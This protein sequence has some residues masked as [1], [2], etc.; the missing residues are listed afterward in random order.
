[1]IDAKTAR[2]LVVESDALMEKY[3]EDLGKVIEREARLGRSYL[4]PAKT[5]GLQF[6]SLYDVEHRAYR[7]SELNGLQKLIEI[8][9]AILGFSVRLEKQEVQIGGGL[10]SMDDE[11]K[12]EL[13]DYIKITWNK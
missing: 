7:Q 8:R 1:M 11:V 3:L 6:R 2:T 10:G 5:V 12:H 9:L 4:F 13:H